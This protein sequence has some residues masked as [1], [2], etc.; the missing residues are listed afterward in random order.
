[1]NKR[2]ICY[3][4]EFVIQKILYVKKK[5]E[6]IVMMKKNVTVKYIYIQS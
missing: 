6:R 3:T 5:N 2:R 1:M 4:E